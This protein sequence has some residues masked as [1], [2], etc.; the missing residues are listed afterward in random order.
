MSLLVG[1]AAL[2]AIWYLGLVVR[3]ESTTRSFV[4]ST[5]VALLAIAGGI[6]G[7]PLLALALAFCAAGDFA[8]TREGDRAFL[9]GIGTFAA[10]HVAYI[11]L[12]LIHP[13]SDPT[14]LLANPVVSIAVALVAFATVMGR[15][16]WRRAGDL[17][18]AVLAYVPIIVAMGLAALTLAPIGPLALVFPAAACF[19][20]SDAVLA[21]E[22]FLLPDD[23]PVRRLTPYIIWPVYWI[24]QCGFLLAF[25]N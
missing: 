16:L 14:R 10:G 12:F 18:G 24:S 25:S 17:S 22:T 5:S 20:A 11:V 9:A 13:A 6:Y 1:A 3:P 21:S 15:I 2:L 8:L 4:K 23:H 19:I 7:P